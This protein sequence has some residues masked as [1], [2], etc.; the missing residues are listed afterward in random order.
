MT[1]IVFKYNPMCLGTSI[2]VF[3]RNSTHFLIAEKILNIKK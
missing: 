1:A 3:V 2:Y